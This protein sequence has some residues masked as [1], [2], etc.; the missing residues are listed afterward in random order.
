MRLE[1]IK[2]LKIPTFSGFEPSQKS[3]TRL[4]SILTALPLD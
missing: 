4:Q 3:K 2:I 1:E